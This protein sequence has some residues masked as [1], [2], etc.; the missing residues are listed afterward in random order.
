MAPGTS[1]HGPVANAQGQD[2]NL[3]GPVVAPAPPQAPVIPPCA[4]QAP[5]NLQAPANP[6]AP[7]QPGA[8]YAQFGNVPFFA[9]T[10]EQ[11]DAR[12]SLEQRKVEADLAAIEARKIREIEE[13]R[14]KIAAIQSA[15]VTA[16]GPRNRVDEEEPA[17]EISPAALLVASRYP[18][19]PKAEI[20]QQISPR[21][22]L[23]TSASEGTRR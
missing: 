20:A 3:A 19:L 13:S 16:A 9:F 14:A 11:L 8:P 2:S 21:E 23:Q 10:Q 18:K 15:A 1:S 5:A 6:Q 4:P 12:F 17:G 22:P 7:A